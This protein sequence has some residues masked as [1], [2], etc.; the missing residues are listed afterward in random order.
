MKEELKH[1]FDKTNQDKKHLFVFDLANNHSGDVNRGL[2]IIREINEVT[3][4]FNLL[5]A[6]KFQYRDLDSFIHPDFKDRK[7]IK[8]VKR[9]SETRLKEEEFK[10]M[11]EELDKLEIITVCTPFDEKSVD[12]I[13]KQNFDII[14]IA[15]CSFTDWPLLERIAKSD[16]PIIASTA[17]NAIEDIDKVVNFFM[18]RNKQFCLM[19][20]VAEYPT[21]NKN[22]QLNQI[23]LLKERYPNV[24]IGFSTHENPNNL[25]SVKIA[26][27]KG[28]IILERHVAIGEERNLYSSS[29]EQ[30]KEWLKS[31]KDSIEMIG[32]YNERVPV[33]E[34][35]KQDLKGLR[36]AVFAKTNIKAG[37]KIDPSKVFY[38]IPSMED[39]IFAND[40]TKYTHYYAKSDI[41][42]RDP[43]LLKNL[44]VVDTR[45]KIK[46]IVYDNI[47]CILLKANLPLNRM[48][49][50]EI[51]HHYGIDKFYEFGCTMITCVNRDYC[52]K[53]IIILPGQTN[54]THVH[55]L[56]EESFIVDYGDVIV[57]VDGIKK[58]FK[59]GDII[60]VKPG[61]KHSFTSKNG[62]IFEEIS[63]THYK[64]DSYYEDESINKNSERKTF[65][66][67]WLDN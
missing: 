29:P 44:E 14:K 36:R 8:Y 13:E 42:E 62:G 24:N 16:K 21:E 34:K 48:L 65:V 15:S 9:F 51:S 33:T 1:I 59:R 7:D 54:P 6:F 39:Q 63:T 31:A 61:E 30:I 19:H 57:D 23:D 50:L 43:I 10:I 53:I 32:V 28:A 47:K 60:L 22:L 11:K 38:A 40:M 52:K 2:Q 26:I 20:C 17:G 64:N 49:D 3:K 5:F 45:E 56:K 18:N 41:N 67:L 27:A 4:N 25:D 12:L 35:E 66:K 55:K 46:K 58:E 37:E